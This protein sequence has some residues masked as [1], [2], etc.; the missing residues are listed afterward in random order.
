MTP[1]T[2]DRPESVGAA[3]NLVY[4][5]SREVVRGLIEYQRLYGPWE[6]CT[7]PQLAFDALPPVEEFRGDGLVATRGLADQ[8]AEA[9]KCGVSTVLVSRVPRLSHI[10]AVF[11]DD[12]AVGQL[13]AEHL[14]GLGLPHLAVVTETGPPFAKTRTEAF[15]QAVDAGTSVG[16]IPVFEAPS[17]F[18]MDLP[19]QNRLRR[20]LVDL[21]L[22]VGIFATNDSL[23]CTV[24]RSCQQAGLAAGDEVAVLGVDNDEFLCNSIRP[25]LSSIDINASLIGYEAASLLDRVMQGLDLSDR[26]VRVPPRGV[27]QRQSTDLLAVEDEIVRRAIGYIRGNV[28]G[29]L[30][31]SDVADEVGMSTKGLYLRFRKAVGHTVKE[32]I[33]QARIAR[34]RQLLRETDLPMS[35]VAAAAGFSDQ[36]KM[37]VAFREATGQ[38]PTAYRT[39]FRVL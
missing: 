28:A 24:L 17:D 18:Q 12:V 16:E 22:P 3:A 39:Q 19:Q 30:R 36:S 21:P 29:K 9:R 33:R 10:P 6:I 27:V 32:E 1:S 5:F 25:T 20:W 4:G 14:R 7:S 37:G 38:T 8:A 26:A 2:S 31:T 11:V 34:L 35:R 23:G 15:M 13:A